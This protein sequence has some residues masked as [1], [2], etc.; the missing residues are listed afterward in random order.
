[1]RD[2]VHAHGRYLGGLPGPG[3]VCRR[4]RVHL[5]EE[6]SHE[7]G[8]VRTVH[9]LNHPAARASDAPT[10]HVE[11]VYRRVQVVADEGEYVRVRAIIQ[12]DRVALQHRAQRLDVIAQL[13][14][15]LEVQLRRRLAHLLL[16]VTDDGPRTTLHELTQPFG[17]LAML[18]H[19]NT[20]HAR[21]RTL[22][23]VAEQARTSLRLRPLE[24]ARRA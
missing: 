22:I 14:R 9:A 23:D 3:L 17:E 24:H 6:A 13:R 1:M 20:A 11:D 15:T 12:H 18:L 19:R 10:A 5:L 8:I 7:R 4:R 21:R 16:Q 2:I